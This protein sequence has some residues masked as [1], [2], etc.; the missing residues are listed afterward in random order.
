MGRTMDRPGSDRDPWMLI[1]PSPPDL[2]DPEVVARWSD[3]EL[4]WLLKHG[5]KDTGMM[6]V[7]PTHSDEDIWGVT[8]FVRQLPEMTAEQYSALA[9][10]QLELQEAQQHGQHG[11]G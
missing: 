3:V 5:I 6:A 4:F 1:Y 7:G 11:G 9:A 8:A 2:T 10:H